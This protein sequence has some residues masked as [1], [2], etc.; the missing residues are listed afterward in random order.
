[1]KNIIKL[2]AV[3][4]VAVMTL[5][6]F[7]ACQQGN[8]GDTTK[9]DTTAAKTE[10]EKE[11][12]KETDPVTTEE[13]TTEEVTTEEVTTEPQP[14]VRYDVIRWDF[15]DASNLGWEATNK[16]ELLAEEDGSLH[17][18]VTGGDPH[19]STKRIPGKVECDDVEYIVIRIKN[20][21]DA[22]T[23][24]LFISTTDSPG[25]AEQYSYKYDYEYADEDDEWEI[26]EI[27]TL[28]INGWSGKLR[29][30]RFDY[31][32]GSEGDCYVDYI[33]LQ[34]TDA[35]KQGSV[36]TEEVV[37]PRAGKQVLYKWDF[38]KLTADDIYLSSKPAE[39]EEGEGEGEG[40]EEEYD[41]RWHFSG[42]VEDAYVENGHLVIKIGGQ[43]PFM[44]SPEM[45]EAF[46]CSAITAIVI[47]ACNK[48][49]MTSAQF[50]F[51][52]DELTSYS[53]A[54]SVRFSFDHKGADNDV[55]E[56][57]VIVPSDSTLWEGQL[58]T[59]RIDPSEEWE[60]IVLLD[61]CELWG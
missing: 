21:T 58:L 8:S 57:I 33:A 47:K 59:I 60:G 25:P 41:P 54:G 31:S 55:F 17:L 48:T 26:I 40:G 16:T 34:T 50:F 24:Q 22:Y 28:D 39:T 2:I 18:K 3:I 42:G 10:T 19:I 15:N 9:A 45:T 27:D 53:E 1:M 13:V 52:S 32:D 46:D 35:S 29:S 11:T 4:I 56:E 38:T 6:L 7:A 14:E 5:T 44:T 30:L 23:G 37:D 49:T 51:T 61:Y 12:E 43:D 20:K 36:E